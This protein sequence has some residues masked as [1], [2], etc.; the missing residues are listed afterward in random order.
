MSNFNLKKGDKV[1]IVSL[2]S[3]I[4]GELYVAH[5]LELGVKRLKQ[6]G[7]VPVFMNNSLKGVNYLKNHPESRAQD[8]KQAFLDKDI[9]MIITA[10]GGDDTYKTIP[11]LMEDKEFINCVKKNPKIFSGFSDTTV[12]HFMLNKLGLSTF[13][14]PAFLVDIAELDNE[15]ID[16]TKEYFLKFFNNNDIIEI[17]SSPVW[18]DN[19]DSY[20]ATQLG[21]SRVCH[22]ETHGF[23]TLNGHGIITGKLFG[24]CINSIYDILTGERYNEENVIFEKYNLLPTI[25]EWKDKVLFLETSEEIVNPERLEIMLLELKKRKILDSVKGLLIGK[26]MDEIYYEEYKEIYKK[27]FKN[28]SVPI[29]YNINFGHAVPRCFLQYNALVTVDYDNKTINVKSCKLL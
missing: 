4:L 23:E 20:D 21:I 16:Y 25:E 1:V 27:I 26:P 28:S 11:Y 29:L 24:G 15:M 17:K 7:L 13:Y 18:Y 9:K 8:L 2:S 14:G 10:I 19:R 3:G 22:S 5:E 6:F 12:N